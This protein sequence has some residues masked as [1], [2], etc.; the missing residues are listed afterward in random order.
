M[1]RMSWSVFTILVAVLGLPAAAV[2]ADE[3]PRFEF[4][5]I[6]GYRM[7]GSFDVE[8]NQTGASNSVDV[9]DSGSWGVDVGIYRDDVSFFEL[10][11]S[12]Q[13]AG[14][15]TNLPA[16]QGADLKTEYIQ[17]GGT[18]FYPQ[19]TWFVPYLS[20]TLGATRFDP[21]RDGYGAETDFSMSLGGGMRMPINKHV[22]ATFG[23]RGYVTFIN[24]D[25]KIFCVSD[26]GGANCLLK[27]SGNSFF[28][29]ET[30]LGLS[31]IF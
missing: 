8:N 16:F 10:L 1:R 28:Q 26:A 19:D 31:F 2:L 30:Q 3:S 21:Q 27:S 7:G 20:M 17:F 25:T 18:M 23:V 4:T 29:G 22:S 6:A 12:Q 14:L 5:P 9:E 11:Y 15:N 24:S 13:S